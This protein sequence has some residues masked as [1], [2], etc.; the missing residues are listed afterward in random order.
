[1]ARKLAMGTKELLRG[2][3]MAMVSEGQITLKEGAERVGVSYRQAK[4]IISTYRTKGDAGLLH[5]NQGKKSNRAIDQAVREQIVKSYRERYPDFGPTF[6]AEKLEE[7]EGVKISDETLRQWLIKEGLWQRK[8][9]RAEHRS[10]RDRR[11]CFGDLVQFDG[12]HHDWFEGRRVKCCLMNMVDDATG[13]TLSMM[14]EEETIEAAMKT[15]WAWI[16]R[17]GLPKALYCD[18]K[19]A[20][21][22][23]REPTDAELLKG[24]TKPKSH[25]GRACDKLGIEV[26]AANSPQAK[27]RVERNHGVY[28]DRFVK[29]LRLAGI[30]T[31]EAANIFLAKTYLPKINAK[32]AVNPSDSA[33]GHAP[34]LGKD[35]R[36]IF[37][38]EHTRSVSN[39]YVVKF[40]CRFFQIL[41]ENRAKPGPRDKVVIRI[42]L[43]GTLDIYWQGK[44]LL[45]KE[46]QIKNQEACLTDAA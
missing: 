32:F 2:K 5:G 43:S 45:V 8:R 38:F 36:E 7:V 39:D 10:R 4:R 19:N 28:Q 9:K 30:S 42:R 46:I 26:I 21:V 34:L 3:V 6:A 12:S 17:Y 33:D 35:L 18:K 29:E 25:F 15:L 13:K 31:I 41:K 16:E 40:E 27:G 24:I 11:P 20:F 1:M 23:T 44:A 22:L 37:V 14:F